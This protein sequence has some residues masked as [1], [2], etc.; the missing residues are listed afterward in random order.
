MGTN[1]ANREPAEGTFGRS[2]EISD[3]GPGAIG[4]HKQTATGSGA[5][6][7]KSFDAGV[8]LVHTDESLPPLKKEIGNSVRYV[9]YTR[10]LRG[11]GCGTSVTYLDVDT[12]K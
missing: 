1:T 9:W 7:K 4:A 3:G 6:L 8:D 11:N 10:V 5:V 2:N 12:G